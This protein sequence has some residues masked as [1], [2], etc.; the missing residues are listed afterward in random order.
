LLWRG[1]GAPF[2]ECGA[3]LGGVGVLDLFADGQGLGGAGD[4][5]RP[6]PQLVVGQ[7]GVP[8]GV[9]LAA[10]V[11]YLP[12]DDQGLLEVVDGP[13]WLADLP[14]GDP[15]VAE[16]DAFATSITYRSGD[17]EGLIEVDDGSARLA[18]F[19]ILSLGSDSQA[20]KRKNPC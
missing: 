20:Q 4:G 19:I 7:G 1:R 11:T 6:L 15:Q 16:N 5:L 14:I 9:A 10:P 3:D 13:A 2:R 12:G 17:N 8:E 18:K